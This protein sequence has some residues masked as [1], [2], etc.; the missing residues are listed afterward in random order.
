MKTRQKVLISG[1][2]GLLALN[3]ALMTRYNHEVLLLMNERVVHLPDTKNCEVNLSNEEDCR[4]VI[5]NFG[6]DLVVNA[7]AMTDVNACEQFPEFAWRANVGVTRNLAQ[8]VKNSPD[9][10]FVQISSDHLF[11]GTKAF[12]DEQNKTY[13]LNVYAHT[14]ILAE[15]TVR[16]ILNN[17]L[18][19]RTNFFGWGTSYR[20]SFSDNILEKLN[21]NSELKLYTDSYFTPMYIPVLVCLI[22]NLI[23]QNSTGTFNISSNERISKYDFGL[24]ISDVF[25]FDARNI[26]P[27]RLAPNNLSPVRPLDLSLSNKK[28]SQSENLFVPSLRSMLQQMVSE[29]DQA[30]ILASV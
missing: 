27:I 17:Y 18:I 9:T 24:E 10:K 5:E 13:P 14:K 28:L 1:G 22:N 6:P 15:N 23:L 4:R 30:Q 19:I 21:S 26:T 12:Y 29:K 7:A 8:A 3:W 2:S 16:E 20:K 25:G 11:C